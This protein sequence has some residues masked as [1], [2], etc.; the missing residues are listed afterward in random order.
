MWFFVSPHFIQITIVP[1]WREGGIIIKMEKEQ[2]VIVREYYGR[3]VIETEGFR[4]CKEV[5]RIIKLKPKRQ[6]KN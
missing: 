5:G 4:E 6:L 1:S 3:I 2:G